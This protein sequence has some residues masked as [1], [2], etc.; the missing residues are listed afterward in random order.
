MIE[1]LIKNE[2][3]DTGRE[4]SGKK[5]KSGYFDRGDRRIV[6][7]RWLRR[8]NENVGARSKPSQNNSEDAKAE[9]SL[10]R[11]V[12]YALKSLGESIHKSLTD[13]LLL[14]SRS[15]FIKTM[16]RI[17]D[18]IALVSVT[19]VKHVQLL[20]KKNSE[21]LPLSNFVIRRKNSYLP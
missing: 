17:V 15:G 11:L 10:T 5:I 7:Q 19:G 3:Y 2:C 13:C 9:E 6:Y 18:F 16:P 4:R 20:I 1:T 12:S 8:E 14:K 21:L